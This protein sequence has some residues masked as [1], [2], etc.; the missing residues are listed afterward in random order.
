MKRIKNYFFPAFLTIL[1]SVGVF[2]LFKDLLPDRLFAEVTVKT[3]NIVVDSLML[4]ALTD[5]ATI[6]IVDTVPLQAN[7]PDSIKEEIIVEPGVLNHFFEK[8]Y[9]VEKENKGSVRVAYFGDSMIEGDL[10]VQDIRKNYQDKYGGLGVG[11]VPVSAL[12]PAQSIS[13]RYEYSPKW[14]TYSFLTKT[15]EP[16]GVSGAVSFV[17]DSTDCWTKYRAGSSPLIMPKLLYGKSSNMQASVKII[18]DSD[19]SKTITLQPKN[20]LNKVSLGSFVTNLVFRVSNGDSIPFYGVDFSDKKGVHIDNFASRGNSG[21]PL[22]TFN[23]RLM[24]AFQQELQYDLIILQYGTNVINS[25]STNYDWYAKRMTTTVNHLKRCFPKADILVISLADKAV[26]Q[27]TE[28]M[29]DSVLLPLIKAQETYALN[30]G[31]GFINLFELMGGEGS[32]VEWVEADPPLAA[33]DYTHF[34]SR[35]SKKVA[36]LIFEKLEED[37]KNFKEQ[38][39]L[40]AEGE[41]EIETE[42]AG[43]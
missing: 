11:F 20:T 15:P 10:I 39:S 36:D 34:S 28:M 13:I 32:M 22:S 42:H 9:F 5:T 21:L 4:E 40:E 25:K 2:Y 37:Y 24:N 35:G 31:S 3:D 18:A 26:K 16:V 30:T 23:A 17:K 12:S 8:L 14:K 1:L 7:H 41:I 19:S 27:G 38:N 29:T 43:E 6:L 33:K